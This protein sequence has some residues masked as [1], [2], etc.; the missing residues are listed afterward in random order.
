M[1]QKSLSLALIAL[2]LQAISA[3]PIYSQQTTAESQHIAKM[4]TRLGAIGVAEKKIVTVT[5]RDGAK[6]RGR[7]SEMKEDT[8]VITDDK[9]N[10]ASTVAYSDVAQVKAKSGGLSTLAK[11]GIGVGAAAAAFVIWGVAYSRS[12]PTSL[13][14]R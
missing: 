7:V 12:C 5:Q 2:L 14:C 8:F 10:A 13:P 9:T 11:I 6:L 4:K 3:A 1:I